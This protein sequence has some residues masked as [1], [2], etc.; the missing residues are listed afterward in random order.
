[1]WYLLAN[2]KNDS[3]NGT[4]YVFSFDANNDEI[5]L[6]ET[7]FG[8]LIGYS[9]STGINSGYFGY[10]LFD[11]RSLNYLVY[12]SANDAV[13]ELSESI[14]Y[15]QSADGN[16]LLFVDTNGLTIASISDDFQWTLE[17]ELN[18]CHSAVW[19]NRD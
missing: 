11:S 3:P 17:H 18:S 6:I 13:K 14:P 2:N 8:Q 5:D 4:G 10:V 16:W 7:Y 19:I 15:D 9:S 1:M 12:D